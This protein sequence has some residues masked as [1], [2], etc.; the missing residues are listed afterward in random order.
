MDI[1]LMWGRGV[2]RL[3]KKKKDEKNIFYSFRTFL[4]PPFPVHSKGPRGY[5]CRR[6]GCRYWQKY[7]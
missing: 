4:L 1:K 6:R 2:P 5:A 3:H 7:C